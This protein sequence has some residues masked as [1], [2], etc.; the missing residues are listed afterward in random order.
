MALNDYSQSSTTGEFLADQV[1]SVI[2]NIGLEKFAAF[3]TDSGSNCRR[4]REI[5]EQNYPHVLNIR[6]AAHAINLIAADFSKI[7]KVSTFISELNKVVRFFKNS[8]VAHN[9][10]RDGLR[11][12]KI[13][14]GGLRTYVK[15][16]WGSLFD[17]VDSVIRARPVFD[18]V[19]K[20][21]ALFMNN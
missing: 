9:E 10:L 6:C 11:N 21:K 16:R 13:S 12:M 18:W 19:C 5:I 7:P 15:T 8:H 14:G 4:A 3:V 20:C 17:A 2:E 1:S